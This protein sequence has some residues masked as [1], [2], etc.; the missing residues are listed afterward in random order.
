MVFDINVIIS[1]FYGLFVGFVPSFN[2]WFINPN[3]LVK[4]FFT[5][6]VIILML[7]SLGFILINKNLLIYFLV[8]YLVSLLFFKILLIRKFIFE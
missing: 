3:N 4:T 7:L 6:L 2:I 8:S 1:I 5:K